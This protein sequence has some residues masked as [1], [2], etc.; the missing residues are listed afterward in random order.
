MSYQ[1]HKYEEIDKSCEYVDKLR[2]KSLPG[3]GFEHGAL[4]SAAIRTAPT[5]IVSGSNQNPSLS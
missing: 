3:A 4:R 1:L 5:R 2:Y